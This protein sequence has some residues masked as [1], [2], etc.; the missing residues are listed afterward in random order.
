MV[1]RYAG[2]GRVGFLVVLLLCSTL[3]LWSWQWPHEESRV[4]AGFGQSVHDEYL[5][6]L[7]LVAPDREFRPVERGEVVFRS[8]PS[9]L[10]HIIPSTLGGV[11][12]LEHGRNFRSLY[13]HLDPD[14]ID[15]G[16]QSLELDDVVGRIGPYG[17]NSG[18]SLHIE[19]FDFEQD[20]RVNPLLLLP[21]TDKTTSPVVSAVYLV[22]VNAGNSGNDAP[23]TPVQG[24]IITLSAG[25]WQL[26]LESYDTMRN[27][28]SSRVAPH[29]YTVRVNGEESFRVAHDIAGVR[30]GSLR[31]SGRRA[32]REFYGESGAVKLSS[33]EL[34]DTPL[35]VDIEVRDHVGNLTQRSFRVIPAVA[36]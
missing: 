25:E 5:V 23:R 30:E 13:G 15:S 12:V 34:G 24:S 11:V 7:K 31:L 1:H 22:S 36:E 19:I 10:P 33:F 17:F 2:I 3:L 4:F 14:S 6:G 32:Y 28:G 18:S 26:E 8:R 27:S 20:V 21:R 35:D 29:S 16:V 9:R